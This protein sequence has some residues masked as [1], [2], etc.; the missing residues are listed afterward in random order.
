MCSSDAAI[1]CKRPWSSA[2][3]RPAAR[4]STRSEVCDVTI[5]RN[6]IKSNSLTRVSAISTNT[7]LNRAAENIAISA[8]FANVVRSTRPGHLGKHHLYCPVCLV[9]S[10]VPAIDRFASIVWRRGLHGI[11]EPDE[12]IAGLGI[13]V[14]SSTTAAHGGWPTP[15]QVADDEAGARVSPKPLAG[16]T[17]RRG[18][19]QCCGT[20]RAGGGGGRP[21]LSARHRRQAFS[22]HP[23]DCSGRPS[24][25]AVTTSSGCC[26]GATLPTETS[27]AEPPSEQ[28]GT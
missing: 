5:C 19:L 10:Q 8:P 4:A 25:R 24:P 3:I 6:S 7:S 15:L 27:S 26:T 14:A 22:G 23:R 21:Q 9:S 2:S 12:L 13:Y 11:D 16:R 1:N 28:S 17:A 20:G 18:W